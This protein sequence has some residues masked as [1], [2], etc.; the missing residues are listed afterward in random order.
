MWIFDKRESIKPYEYDVKHFWD[1][2]LHSF[3]T[4]DE[5]NYTS[6]VH[7][8]KVNM[9][10]VEKDVTIKC[11]LAISNVEIS[12]KAFWWELWRMIPKPEIANVWSIYWMNETIHFNLY[13]HLIEILWLNNEFEKVNQIP[14]I[15]KRIKYLSDC[16]RDRE[17]SREDFVRCLYFFTLFIENVS[18][19]SQFLI[20]MS[21]N[22]HKIYL[23]WMVNGISSSCLEE[24]LHA[25]FWTHLIN[26]IKKEYPEITSNIKDINI[27]AKQ[28]LDAEIEIIDWIF[29]KWELDYLKKSDV[30]DYI[31]YRM[32]K[33][34]KWI[35]ETPLDETQYSED[36][37]W[38]ETQ[39]LTTS[40]SDFFSTKSR[41]YS[42][43]NQSI[44]VDDLF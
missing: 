27:I 2:I 39:L 14:A 31:K 4:H 34:L 33:W 12:I 42:K 38:F 32:N 19:F 25:D 9:N 36:I 35:W 37:E 15:Q 20:L 13:S 24:N 11:M 8:F 26:I 10:E 29:E 43:K 17:K 1:A 5:Y 23:K 28:A 16:L 3:W 21:I 30:V 7:D 22:K 18:L 44:N 6:D 41:N 40:H